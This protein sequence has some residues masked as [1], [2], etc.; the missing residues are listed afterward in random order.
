MSDLVHQT[1]TRLVDHCRHFAQVRPTSAS[2]QLNANAHTFPPFRYCSSTFGCALTIRARR[3]LSEAASVLV[4][5]WLAP[6]PAYTLQ[7]PPNFSTCPV[8][9]PCDPP[10]DHI[11]PSPLLLAPH[12]GRLAKASHTSPSHIE[13]LL[14]P[15]FL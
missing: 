8:P 15:C 10:L 9:H 14:A 1:R 12:T 5:T 7:D 4:A 6:Q 3:S 13:R 11:P 2:P